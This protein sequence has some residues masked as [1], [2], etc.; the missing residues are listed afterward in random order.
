MQHVV[1]C[2]VEA[3]LK[4][5]F[6]AGIANAFPAV[7]PLPEILITPG[8]TAEFQCNNAMGLAKKL[9]TLTPPV[10]LSPEQI[11]KQIVA[12]IPPNDLI[13][14]TEPT[15]QGFINIFIAKSWVAETVCRVVRTGTVTPP[16]L[17]KKERVLVD[18]SSP[19]IAKEMHVGHLRSTI[20]GETVCRLFEF[21]GLETRRI[22][23]VGDWGTQFGML[24]LLLKQQHP[25]FLTN[26]PKLSD[27]QTFY[28][29]A[30]VKFDEDPEFKEQARLEVVKLQALEESSIAAW[31]L[32]CKLSEAEFNEIYS[33]LGVHSEIRGESFYNP[34]IP[35]V[36]DLLGK[37][38]LLQESDGAQIIVSTEPKAVSAL[39]SKDMARLLSNHFIERKHSG[40]TIYSPVLLQVLR[41]AQLLTKKEDGTEMVSVG[42]KETKKWAD[43]DVFK[44]LEKLSK[45]MEP[46]Y[47]PKLADVLAAEFAKAGALEGETMKVPRFGFPLI[48]RKRDGGYTYDTTDLAAIWHRFQ[49]EKYDRVVYITDLGQ[50]EHFKMVAQAA[51]DIKWMEVEK[52][53]RWCHAGFGVVTGADGKKIKTRSGESTKL[54]DLLDEA[55][56]RALEN[57]VER[58]KGDRSQGHSKEYMEELSKKIGYGAVKYFDLKRD[59]TTDYPF[60]YDKMLDFSGNTAVFLLYAYA[61]MVSMKRKAGVSDEEIRNI[62]AITFTHE[63]EKQLA[64]AALNFESMILKTAEDLYP[65]HIC[66][67]AYEMVGK[68]GE[69]YQHCQVVGGEHQASRLALVELVR[70]H[71][72][73]SLELLGVEVADRL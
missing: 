16:V 47:K 32:F 52:G 17:Q 34:F 9:S 39:D 21:L 37:A 12:A 55:C 53:Q 36:L 48:A 5:L 71:L 46:L 24:I 61:R 58:E 54:K 38:G 72:Y 66:D 3:S 62:S 31:R 59:R 20:I 63:S 60:D 56:E 65:H 1:S 25:D 42:K 27:L 50:F 40:E 28:K 64:L 35:G 73:K 30:K 2:N 70:L 23:H 11:G 29:A 69:F 43:F 57:L 6:R 22:N 8:R 33:R 4:D 44:D 45:M 26:Q 7:D 19:N 49:V 67:Y 13:E 68:L 51:E 41:D 14:R 10:K 18:F 15:P